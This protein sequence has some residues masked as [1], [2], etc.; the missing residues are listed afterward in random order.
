MN[1]T[2]E[3]RATLE[4]AFDEARARRHEYVTLEHL[5]LALCG[6]L[7]GLKI[8]KATGVDVDQLLE[9]IEGYLDENV[10][11]V[12]DGQELEPRQTVAFWRVLQRAAMHVQSSGKHEI[13]AGNVLASLFREDESQ[14]V[15]LLK[16]QGITR[17]D[18]TRFLSHGVRK[19]RALPMRPIGEAEGDDAFDEESLDNPLDAFTT[20]L[21]DRAEKGLIDPLVGRKREVSLVCETPASGRP[22]SSR[23]W[24]SPSTRGTSPSFSPTRGSTRSIWVPCW[25]GRATA[26]T[27]RSGSRR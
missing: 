18:I 17:L 19:Q 24:R 2:D 14:A 27:S 23:G 10:D 8:L 13:S 20:D 6:N 25:R 22:R 9:D 21:V 5:L 3:L 16:K 7:E 4:S 26:V 15:F 12:P 11:P 1:I